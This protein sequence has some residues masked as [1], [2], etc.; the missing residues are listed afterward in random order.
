MRKL[1]THFY[2]GKLKEKYHK[3]KESFDHE[4]ALPLNQCWNEIQQLIIK[5]TNKKR[6]GQALFVLNKLKG[7][8]GNYDNANQIHVH[9]LVPYAWTRIR[10]YDQSGQ[11]LFLEQLIDIT[12]G[13]C[14]QGRVTRILQVVED[15]IPPKNE[16][17]ITR[18]EVTTSYLN[19][20]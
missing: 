2:D 9:E 13:M 6:R 3:L 5:H 8:A 18:C 14:P 16:P 11:L 1:N 15:P 10:K 4:E 19:I 17:V 7:Q 20:S 12:R